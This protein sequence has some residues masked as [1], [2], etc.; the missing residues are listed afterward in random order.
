[1]N[2]NDQWILPEGIEEIL[3]SQSIQLEKICR[4]CI[5]YFLLWGYEFVIPP[6][7]E[8]LE[9]LLI[10]NEEDLDLQTFKLIDQLNGRL[11]GVRADITPQIARIDAHILKREAPTR[12]C[13]LGEVYRTRPERVGASRNP[14]QIGAELYGHAGHDSDFEIINLLIMSLQHIGLKNFHINIGHLGIYSFLADNMA[15]KDW[16]RAEIFNKLQTKATDEIKDLLQQ[17]HIDKQ[18][19]QDMLHLIELNGEP[20]TTL[21]KAINLFQGKDTILSYINDLSYMIDRIYECH[22]VELSVDLADSHGYHYHTG[23]LFM[24]YANHSLDKIGLG[25][26]YDNVSKAFGRD[27]PATG[28]SLDAKVLLSLLYKDDIK[29]HAIFAPSYNHDPKLTQKINQLRSEE[30][31]V[32]QILN[33][34]TATAKEMRCNRQLVLQQDQWVVIPIT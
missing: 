21:K 6:L 15:L 32:I 16:Q 26:R 28:F 29:P 11:M 34:Q 1:M 31:I 5:D 13:Y 22:D 23:I 19:T 3:P 18:L 25:G 9:P 4:Q 24:A 33:G 8:Y 20:K 10:Y 14:L 17:W 12:M 27:R 7:I 2:K 30:Q